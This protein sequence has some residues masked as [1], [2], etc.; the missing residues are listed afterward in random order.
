MGTQL[1][2][3]P[4]KVTCRL[5]AQRSDAVA[6]SPSESLRN[7]RLALNN[8]AS[9]TLLRNDAPTLLDVSEYEFTWFSN[10]HHELGHPL[11]LFLAL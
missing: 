9:L 2:N 1:R 3:V 5:R 8:G 10:D 11:E 7:G 4:I 6:V